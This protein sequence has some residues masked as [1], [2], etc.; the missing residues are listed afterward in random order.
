MRIHGFLSQLIIIIG[1]LCE[2]CQAFQQPKPLTY[3][4]VS[5]SR[6]IG[7]SPTVK[8]LEL[9]ERTSPLF[10]MSATS[11]NSSSSSG[12]TI[13]RRIFARFLSIKSLRRLIAPLVLAVSLFF[14]SPV[15][16][17]AST[18]TPST[19]SQG[20]TIEIMSIRPGMSKEQADL[21]IQGKMDVETLK[22][23]ERQSETKPL[24]KRKQSQSKPVQK[25][26]LYGDIEDEDDQ[27]LLMEELDAQSVAS[28]PSSS[29]SVSSFSGTIVLSDEQRR[30]LTRKI[31]CAVFIPTLG[32]L[33]GR[34]YIRRRLEA[35]YIKRGLAIQEAQ[36]AEY[37]NVTSTSQS[38]QK[39]E[40]SDDDD[41]DDE[42]DDDDPP[43]PPGGRPDRPPR[44][45][46]PSGSSGGGRRGPTGSSSGYGR[47]NDADIDRLKDL[48]KKS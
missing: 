48:F 35:R 6:M 33:M 15:T 9:H 26:S 12:M 44:G 39:D 11:A 43:P 16:V 20:E 38:N 36:R 7:R 31:Y 13:W 41:S 27:D 24:K 23:I 10:T 3:S 40:T 32:F 37:L 22:Q 46:G 2:P 14:S 30:V 29:K 25:R 8:P 21:V 4:R 34:E 45:D 19:A 42:D 47:A 5:F 28:F 18:I 1:L 17:H